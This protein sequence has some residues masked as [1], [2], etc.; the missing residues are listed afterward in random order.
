MATT[1]KRITGWQFADLDAFSA[2]L[3]SLNESLG[4]PVSPIAATQTAMIE[5]PN[6]KDD[7]ITFYYTGYNPQFVSV[8]GDPS[9]FT[10]DVEVPDVL[11][12]LT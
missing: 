6:I 12:P 9:S 5:Q 2:A 8:L 1:T 11:P 4:I 7:V 10:I 3:S